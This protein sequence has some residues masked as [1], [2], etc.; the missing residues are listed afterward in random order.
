VSAR[1]VLP[2]LGVGVVWL[3]LL[4][5]LVYPLGGSLRRVQRRGGRLTLANFVEF[6]AIGSTCA[7]S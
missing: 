5:F 6:A 7:R 2:A 3:F 4:L 1:G